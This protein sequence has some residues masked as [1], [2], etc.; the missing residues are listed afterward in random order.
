[1]YEIPVEECQRRLEGLEL[2][3]EYFES[4]GPDSE[5]QC[6]EA[7]KSQ[8]GALLARL[9]ANDTSALDEL[10][11][12]YSGCIDGW[13][14]IL[15]PIK[16][17][18]VVFRSELVAYLLTHSA[19][20]TEANFSSK[21]NVY[22]SNVASEQHTHVVAFYRSKNSVVKSKAKIRKSRIRELLTL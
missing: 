19:E 14:S 7:A 2:A 5:C 21:L 18:H 22:M 3:R 12:F 1:M 10:L 13:A 9:H 16:A 15:Y 11:E 6:R 20:L 8:Q 17:D 4:R